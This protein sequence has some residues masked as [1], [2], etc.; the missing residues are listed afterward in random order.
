MAGRFRLVASAAIG[1]LILLSTPANAQNLVRLPLQPV[2]HIASFPP[3]SIQGLVQDEKSDPVA[4]AIVTAVGANTTVTVTDKN[5]RFELR[6]LPPGPYLLRAHLSGFVT[7]RAQIVQVHSSARAA[8]TIALRHVG[9]ATVLQA[10]LGLSDA[11]PAT[12]PSAD[13]SSDSAATSGDTSPIDQG[14]ID[15]G[16][17]A[18]RIRH[19]RRSILKDL[20][21]PAGILA[22]GNR[23]TPVDLLGRAAGSSARLATSFFADTPFTGQL[24]FLTSGLFDAPQ[25]L[26]SNDMTPKGIANVS[27]SAPLG[28]HADWTA[29]GAMTQ[30]DISSWIVAGSYVRRAPERHQY[31]LGLS[32]SMQ[33]YD[34]SNPLSLRS[35]T[36]GRRT[37]GELYGFDTFT[38]RPALSITYGTRY[39]R[40]DYLEGRS[41]LSPRVEVAAEPTEHLRVSV[42]WSKRAQ[43]PGAEEF[44]PPSDAGIWLPPQ[45][46]FSSFDPGRP[47]RAEETTQAAVKVARDFAGSTVELRAF[48]QHSDEQFAT[49]FGAEIP[50]QPVA[51]IGHYLVANMGAADANGCAA[52][53]HTALS[54]WIRGTV[55]YSMTNARLAG[56]D[57]GYLI[58]AAPSVSRPRAERIHDLATTLETRVPETATRVLVLYRVS[59]GFSRASRPDS[60]SNRPALD[61]RFDVQ[62][63]QSLPFMDFTNARW[64]MLVAVRNFFH[65]T[66]ADQSIYD[67]LLVVHPPKR[68]VGGL[69][70]HF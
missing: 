38:I 45:R 28:G 62:V 66:A 48:R 41:L 5:G 22:G 1:S 9:L 68:I 55:Q 50:D 23:F 53:L 52:A 64:E 6:P 13:D 49:L 35:A 32:Y 57:V 7:A 12:A 44:L 51:K 18:W 67:E 2:A 37:A 30:S 56:G 19:T 40:Y 63:R 16:E 46:T 33:R 11:V 69:T 10:G 24:N 31:D 4:G 36:N 42:Q 47:L 59:N 61:A 17:T 21:L 54:S 27:V 25:Q 3:G 14:A 70:M 60:T 39:A 8:S 65:E 15:Q 29:R 20:T 58:L 26:F 34:G 43:A